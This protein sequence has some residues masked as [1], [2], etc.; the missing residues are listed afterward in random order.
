M[1]THVVPAFIHAVRFSSVGSTAPVAI[2]MVH[3]SGASRFFTNDGPPTLPAG[4]IFTRSHPSSCA[5]PISVADP[6]PGV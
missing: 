6:H 5:V 1:P 3:G 4:N 2:I